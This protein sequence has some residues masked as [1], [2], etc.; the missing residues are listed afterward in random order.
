MGLK[1]N[2]LDD[3][4]SPMDRKVNLALA[5]E[6]YPAWVDRLQQPQL[7]ESFIRECAQ[8]VPYYSALPGDRRDVK[9]LP[10]VDKQLHLVRRDAFTNT[11]FADGRLRR[12]S[13]HTNG[14]LGPS[15][16]VFLDLPSFFD[17]EHASFLR[18][19]SVLPGVRPLLAA[20]EPSVFVV[21]DSPRDLRSSVIMPM[22][23]GTLLRRLVI[24]RDPRS[25]AAAV[26]C[27]RSSQI[28][29]VHGKPSV[30]LRLADLDAEHPGGQHIAPEGVV[31][32]GENLYPDDRDRLSSWYGCSVLNAYATSEAGLVAFECEQRNVLHVLSDH[33]TVEVLQQSGSLDNTGTGELVMTNAVNWRQAFIR[34]RVGDVAHIILER[35]PCGH[36]GQSIDFLPGR[37]RLAYDQSGARIR[38]ADIAAAIGSVE[39]A[40]KQFQ[41]AQELDSGIV[42][43]WISKEHSDHDRAA[44]ALQTQLRDHFPRLRFE[45]RRVASIN[46]PGGKLRRFL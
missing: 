44:V 2:L 40:V 32:S 29:L 8:S 38:S 42:V 7:K 6:A 31:C 30:L 46:G 12:L 41:I 15:L 21:S 9:S 13:T 10:V 14:T 18:F 27:L 25:D 35:C 43:S 28:A 4:T 37:E 36:E 11:G 39:P 17:S 45:L 19:V 20:G 24:S 33:L 26:E 3:E 5:L 16:R 22:L 23:N 1:W 34:Y